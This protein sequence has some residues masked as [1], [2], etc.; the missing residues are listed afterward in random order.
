LVPAA[1]AAAAAAVVLAALCL[2]SAYTWV[3]A[4]DAARRIVREAEAV[5]PRNGELVFLDAPSSYR[6]AHL[7]PQPDMNYPVQETG[8]PDLT[9]AFCTQIHLRYVDRGAVT[10]R[11]VTPGLVL[12]VSTHHGAGI[13]VPVLRPT[14]A[15]TAECAYQPRSSGGWPPGLDPAADV[16]LTPTRPATVVWFDGHDVRRCC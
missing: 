14:A 11:T 9:T 15:L 16:R 7:F 13:D 6:N 2:S 5:G 8:R 10:V 3:V 1:G 12:A 4:G